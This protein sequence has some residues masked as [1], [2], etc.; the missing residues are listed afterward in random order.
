MLILYKH[1]KKMLGYSLSSTV[2]L[3]LGLYAFENYVCWNIL[4]SNIA[5]S[6]ALFS[7]C[8]SNGM[9]RRKGRK[10]V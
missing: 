4:A 1:S 5:D 6:A 3:S 10:G 2:N 9:Q 7:D 8:A